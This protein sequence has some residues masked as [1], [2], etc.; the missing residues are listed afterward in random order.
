MLE[1]RNDI[2]ALDRE[3][4]LA[5]LRQKSAH[6]AVFVRLVDVHSR[7]ILAGLRGRNRFVKVFGVAR[8]LL[9]ERAAGGLTSATAAFG[10]LARFVARFVGNVV[11]RLAG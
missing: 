9:A 7:G 10:P 5:V 1:Q 2:V 6:L 3:S 4:G 8:A 11:A